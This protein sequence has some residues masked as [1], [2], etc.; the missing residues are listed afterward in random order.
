M[1][2][3]LDEIYIKEDLVYE[4][5]AALALI[6]FANI[7]EVNNHLLAFEQSLQQDSSSSGCTQPLAKSV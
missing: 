7:G 4:S 5:T 3:L 2:I 6:G 1:I